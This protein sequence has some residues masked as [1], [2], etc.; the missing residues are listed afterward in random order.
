MLSSHRIVTH[1]KESCLSFGLY[2]HVRQLLVP[3]VCTISV[4]N[5]CLAPVVIPVVELLPSI[6]RRVET[7]LFVDRPG[8][9]RRTVHVGPGGT[10]WPSH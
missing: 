1:L 3:A 8:L 9:E 2:L 10:R 5:A 7:V 4:E 6:V